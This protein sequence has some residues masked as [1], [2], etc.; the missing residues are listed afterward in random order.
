MEKHICPRRGE[1]PPMAKLPEGDTWMMRHG[2]RRCSYCGSMHPDDVMA[3][4]KAGRKIGPTD[5]SYKAY[6]SLPN[7]KA[8]KRIKVGESTGPIH[9]YPDATRKEKLFALFNG[10]LVTRQHYGKGSEMR[11]EKFY[12][13]HFSEAQCREFV[14]LLNAKKLVIGFPGHF[15]RKPFFIAGK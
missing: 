14:A 6:L 5:K 12:F 7:E 4:L 13:Q 2:L 8:G 9:R 3:A 11:Q 15:Y 1:A 10:G